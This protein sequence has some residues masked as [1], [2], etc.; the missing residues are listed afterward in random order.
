MM[1]VQSVVIVCLLTTVVCRGQIWQQQR[2]SRRQQ[3]RLQLKT[4]LN[5]KERIKERINQ[6]RERNTQ[7]ICYDEVGCFNLPHKNSPLQKIPE[8]PQVL[9]TKF[10]LFTRETDFSKPQVLYYEDKGRS[11]NGSSFDPSKPLKIIVHG[12]TSKW[13]EKGS[14]IITNAY[15]KLYDCNVILMDWHIGARGPN[16]PVAAANTELVGRQLG[17]LLTNMV[18]NGLDARKIHLIGFSLGAHVCGTASES[19]KNKGHLLGRITGLDPA[20]PLF[21]NNY[22]REKYKKLDRS[23]AKLVDVVHTDSSPV[24]NL[25]EKIVYF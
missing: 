8:D 14:M 6:Y 15:L 3:A 10:Y 13:N 21:R 17:I 25:T 1:L 11:I 22:L 19:L 2:L 7:S 16:Y 18:R 24:S 9:N 5:L 12:Y 23:D 4:A 20:S